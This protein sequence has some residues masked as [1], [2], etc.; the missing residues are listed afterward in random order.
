[1]VCMQSMYKNISEKTEQTVS[2]V[3]DNLYDNFRCFED[4]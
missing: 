1:M 2:Y 4:L 3:Y